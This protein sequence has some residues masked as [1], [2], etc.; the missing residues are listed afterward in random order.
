MRI[1]EL[2]EVNSEPK[3]YDCRY[4]E[5]RLYSNSLYMEAECNVDCNLGDTEVS[6]E[7]YNE[8][9]EKEL[10]NIIETL[11]TYGRYPVDGIPKYVAY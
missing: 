1:Y 3:K 6:D 7:Q 2:F 5:Y 9:V 10:K 4:A 8:L 11:K